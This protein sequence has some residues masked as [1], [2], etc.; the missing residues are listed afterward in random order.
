MTVPPTCT[1]CGSNLITGYMD[2]D[3]ETGPQR[4]VCPKCEPDHPMS[5]V[6]LQCGLPTTRRQ[7]RCDRHPALLPL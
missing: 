1:T 6:V 5:V 3:D 4:E 7:G 2:G